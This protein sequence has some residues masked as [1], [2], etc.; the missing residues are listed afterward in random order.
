M[1]LLL[2]LISR[3]VCLFVCLF[4]F[5]EKEPVGTITCIRYLD[6]CLNIQ[7]YNLLSKDMNGV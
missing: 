7:L 3:H 2:I 5:P 4:I 6:L 1:T